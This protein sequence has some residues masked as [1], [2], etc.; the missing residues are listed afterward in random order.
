MSEYRDVLYSKYNSTLYGS[1]S[2][3][4]NVSAESYDNDYLEL[5]PQDKRV[6]ILDIGCG[7]GHFLY[8]LKTRGYL[9][10]QGVDHSTEQVDL[11]LEA[12]LPVELIEDIFAYLRN[13]PSTYDVISMNDVLEHFTKDE[14]IRLLALMNQSLRENGSIIIR[15]PNSSGIFGP[16]GRYLDFTHEVGF[17]ESSLR[18]VL[19]ASDFNNVEIRDNKVPFGFKLKRLLRWVLFKLWRSLLNLIFLIE[20]GEVRPKNLGKVLIVK[21]NK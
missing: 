8:Y 17:T 19:Q 21:A 10:I 3:E 20:V 6:F 18:Q 11:C 12:G 7:I 13:H 1:N 15:V 16:H 2:S 14:I 4:L 9:N 5:L